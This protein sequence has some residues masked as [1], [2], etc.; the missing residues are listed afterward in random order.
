MG[1]EPAA[2]VGVLALALGLWWRSRRR[3]GPGRVGIPQELKSARP[4]YA[5]RLFRSKGPIRLVAK[6]DRTYRNAAG[7]LVLIE[8][9]TRTANRVHGSDVIELSAQ[10]L[11]LTAQTGDFVADHGYVLTQHPDGHQTGWHRVR[12]LTHADVRA[13]ILRREELLAGNAEPQFTHSPGV[14]R[15]CTFVRSCQRPWR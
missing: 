11:A 1:L 2:V 14:C 8:L 9:K 3:S 13:L 15:K 6:V 4:L 7:V 10:R 12:L 5:E